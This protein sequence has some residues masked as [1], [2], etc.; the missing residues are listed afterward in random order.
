[1][2]GDFA[3]ELYEQKIL[4]RLL[5]PAELFPWRAHSK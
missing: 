3:T 5:T 1:M 4:P 2:I